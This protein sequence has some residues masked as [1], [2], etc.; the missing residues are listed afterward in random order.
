MRKN[1]QVLF[2]CP[3]TDYPPEE[4]SDLTNYYDSIEEKQ[5]AILAPILDKLLPVLALSAWGGIPDDQ[6]IDFE[7]META[8]PLDNA[9]VVQRKTGAIVTAYQAD[10]IDQETARR[11]LHGMSEETGM[12]DSINDELIGSGKGVTYSQTQ[13][14]RDPM[15][16][17]FDP[18]PEPPAAEE[19]G[20]E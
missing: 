13:Q 9:D 5:S 3:N 4:E 12:F 6:D 8:S 18:H 20:A 10:L 1:T 19:G 17:L 15:A 7:P 2:L 14:M 11:E 16:G